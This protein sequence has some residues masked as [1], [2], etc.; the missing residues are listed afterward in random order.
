MPRLEQYD[1]RNACYVVTS[2]DGKVATY[3]LTPAGEQRLVGAGIS[4][5][6][7]FERAL[8][9]DLCKTGDAY[10]RGHEFA[11]AVRKNQ[12][13][14][15]LAGDPNPEQA[16]PTCDGCGSVIDLHLELTRAD[17]EYVARVHCPTCRAT[18][19]AVANTSIP[20]SLL[21]RSLVNRLFE[22]YA[23]ATRSDNVQRY[24][25]LLDTEFVQRWD[26]VRKQ[27]ATIQ[28]QLFDGDALGG[29][30]IG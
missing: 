12:L 6:Q 3:Q 22:D 11:E 16:F 18:P 4:I 15:D 8:L 25:T 30:G 14:F 2:I 19:K 13:E 17:A 10:G 20:L 5:G 21:S 29:L 23:V 26:M 9:L 24:V 1:G 28:P 27:R 7:T